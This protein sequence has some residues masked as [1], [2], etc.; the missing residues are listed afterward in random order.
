MAAR[1]SGLRCGMSASTVLLLLFVGG[2]VATLLTP[3]RWRWVPI[4]VGC[5]GALG[6]WTWGLAQG[7]DH[8][9]EVRCG[10]QPVL[11]WILALLWVAAWLVGVGVGLLARRLLNRSGEPS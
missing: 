8:D 7:C 2:L 3:W 11:G 4:A 10:W 1:A 9:A 6:W 5:A